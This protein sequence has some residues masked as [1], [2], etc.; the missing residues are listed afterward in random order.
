MTPQCKVQE[1]KAETG[2]IFKLTL[3]PTSKKQHS[4]NKHKMEEEISLAAWLEAWVHIRMN[5]PTRKKDPGGAEDQGERDVRAKTVPNP[6]RY[7]HLRPLPPGEE[8]DGSACR[9]AAH[10]R[11]PWPSDLSA[12]VTGPGRFPE[13]GLGAAAA[14][15]RDA[16]PGPRRP[17]A[18][19]VPAPRASP[20]GP[21]VAAPGIT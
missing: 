19:D 18:R 7:S 20:A 21:R 15:S 11:P 9:S 6:G 4:E 1:G 17:A 16:A 12:P 14:A 5:L 2:G 8:Q 13:L 3:L 10:A